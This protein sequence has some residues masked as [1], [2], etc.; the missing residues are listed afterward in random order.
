MPNKYKFTCNRDPITMDIGDS[1]TLMAN[2]RRQA[3]RLLARRLGF[4][5][6]IVREPKLVADNPNQRRLF[7]EITGEILVK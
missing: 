3:Y 6:K 1:I 7:D 2:D 4:K 5:A